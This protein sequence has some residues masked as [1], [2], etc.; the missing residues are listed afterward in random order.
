MQCAAT[1]SEDEALQLIEGASDES[2]D[3]G[4]SDSDEYHPSFTIYTPLAPDNPP[5]STV[6]VV[7]PQRDVEHAPKEVRTES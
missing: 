6:A 7:L 3:A 1:L 5:R 4:D 2:Q